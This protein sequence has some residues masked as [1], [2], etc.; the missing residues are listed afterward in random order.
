MMNGHLWKTTLTKTWTGAS[1][2]LEVQEA[3]SPCG[4]GKWWCW[5]G[6]EREKVMK[7]E[8]SVARSWLLTGCRKRGSQDW[9]LLPGQ[10]AGCGISKTMTGLLGNNLGVRRKLVKAWD[11]FP[12]FTWKPWTFLWFHSYTPQF[13]SSCMCLPLFLPTIQ[14]L[15]KG[16]TYVFCSVVP[17][18]TRACLC[19]PGP[20]NA[21]WNYL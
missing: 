6:L 15:W 18:S 19:T 17:A 5:L 14:G 13:I 12:K 9:F 20:S 8:Q 16:R 3:V 4:S 2:W 21:H 1:Y 10:V 7:W 11:G